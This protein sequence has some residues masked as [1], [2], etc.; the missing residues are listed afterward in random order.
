[1][2]DGTTLWNGKSFGVRYDITQ[3]GYGADTVF[4][5]GDGCVLDSAHST[6]DALAWRTPGS[7]G[8]PLSY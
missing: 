4:I 6:N 1:M 5:R 7:V 8:R 2:A 3:S